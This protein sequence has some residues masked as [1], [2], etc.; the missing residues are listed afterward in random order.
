[1]RLLLRK[2]LSFFRK[3]SKEDQ[4]LIA[5]IERIVGSKPFNLSLYKLS[6]IHSSIAKA[7]KGYKE[8]NDRLE[9]LGDAV[10]GLVTA[11]YLFKKYPYKTEGFLTEIRARIVNRESLNHLAKKIGIGLIVS[12]NDNR[13]NALSYKSLLG[14]T[15]EALIGAVYIDRG[16][17]FCRR[18]II[19]KLLSPHI[20]IDALVKNNPNYK[21]K[22]IEW[23]HR[24][25]KEVKFEI[26]EVKGYNHHKEFIAQVIID[27]LP[28]GKGAGLSKKRAEQDA[29]E[30]SCLILH[31]D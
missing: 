12:Y 19:R 22:I 4:R 16:Y 20:D 8:S 27:N 1:V 6:I 14:D 2:L 5:A 30:K 23:A 15:L 3:Y 9:Y 25:N 13:R 26:L 17:S 28:V 29:A 7:D 31:I 10:L 18:F 24:E 21:S 11:E